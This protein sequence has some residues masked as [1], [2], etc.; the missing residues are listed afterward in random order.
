MRHSCIPVFPQGNTN[1]YHF[2]RSMQ[3]HTHP[4]APASSQPQPS[5]CWAQGRVSTPITSKTSA[6]GGCAPEKK[7]ILGRGG[8]GSGIPPAALL[9]DSPG[10]IAGVCRE[11]SAAS[12]GRRACPEVLFPYSSTACCNF[13]LFLLLKSQPQKYLFKRENYAECLKINPSSYSPTA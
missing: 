1:T 2:S 13:P 8:S 4:G 10:A 5:T 9:S 6:P 11:L 7:M 12:R 3:I